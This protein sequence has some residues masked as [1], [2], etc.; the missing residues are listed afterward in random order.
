MLVSTKILPEIKQNIEC[1]PY[2][3][4]ILSFNDSYGFVSCNLAG[5]ENAKRLLQEIVILPALRP[6]VHI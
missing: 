2:F 5:M 3:M 6:E 1:N 4:N